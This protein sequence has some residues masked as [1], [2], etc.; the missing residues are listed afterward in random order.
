M[1]NMQKMALHRL[2]N[3]YTNVCSERIIT[4]KNIQEEYGEIHK[5]MSW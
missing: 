5:I 4:K 2:K 1:K 3:N